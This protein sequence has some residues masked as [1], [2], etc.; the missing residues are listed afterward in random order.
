MA[1]PYSSFIAMLIQKSRLVLQYYPESLPG[2]FLNYC[3]GFNLDLQFGIT[4]LSAIY[5]G[6]A[7]IPLFILFIQSSWINILLVAEAKL[8]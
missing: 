2:L 4:K 3:N 6:L 8:C 7:A 5:G 1:C